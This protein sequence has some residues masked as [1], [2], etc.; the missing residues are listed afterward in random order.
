[1]KKRKSIKEKS[2]KKNRPD[3]KSIKQSE[4]LQYMGMLEARNQNPAGAADFFSQASALEPGNPRLLNDLGYFQ[5]LSTRPIEALESYERSLLIDPRAPLTLCNIGL[6][7][8]SLGNSDLAIQ[9][10]NRAL[11]VN[12][13]DVSV[14]C[15]RASVYLA[16]GNAQQALADYDEALSADSDN[17]LVLKGRADALCELMRQE[18][19]ITELNRAIELNPGYAPAWSNR[20]DAYRDLDQYDAAIKDYQQALRLAPGDAKTL[21]NLAGVYVSTSESNAKLAIESTHDSLKATLSEQYCASG[22]EINRMLGAGISLFRL[23]H[24]LGQAQYLVENEPDFD[25]ETARR[26]INA[27]SDTFAGFEQGNQSTDSPSQIPVSRSQIDE[28]R[29]FWESAWRAPVDEVTHC[30]N[31]DNNWEALQQQYLDGKPEIVAIDSFL[32]AEALTALQ[33]HCLSSRVWVREYPNQYLGA[34]AN[35]GFAGPLYFQLARELKERMPRI[36]KNYP[37]N[38]LWAFKYDSRLG[39][40]INIHADFALVNLNFWI[41]PDEFNLAPDCGG[42][43]IYVTPA[44]ANWTFHDYNT[45]SRAMYEHLQQNGSDHQIIE[46]RC[47]RAALFN[48]A[49]FHE[50]DRIE[51]AEGYQSRRVNITYLFGR[52]LG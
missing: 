35:Q 30:L 42:L 31:P 43:K 28:M 17:P 9:Y 3:A 23:K 13:T 38:Q 8:K 40:G 10:F 15:N 33:R 32:S 51:F 16:L 1:M 39:K 7:H 34:F 47:N 22:S 41:T 37:L 48:S 50:T 19:A 29:P 18:E 21:T 25:K 20:A 52:Q 2:N 45:D 11:D 49:L 6:L 4:A 36:F 12:P 46:Y 27:A 24:D 5:Q 14:L 26:F 44:P